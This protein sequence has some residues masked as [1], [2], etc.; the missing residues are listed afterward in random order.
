MDSD[1]T[2]TIIRGIGGF[3]HV[4]TGDTIVECRARG[5][6]RKQNIKPCVGDEVIYELTEDTEEL[7]GVITSIMERKNHF[8]RPPVSNIDQFIVVC[9]LADPDPNYIILDR[10]LLAAERESVDIVICFTKKD[11]AEESVIER[12]K[13]I[14]HDVYP[15]IFLDARD[16]ENVKDMIPYLFDKKSALAGPSGAGK[17]TIL[18]TLRKD[19]GAK[20]GAV[21]EKTGRGRHTTRHVELFRMDFGGMVFDTPGFT[22]FDI[23]DIQTE[24]LAELYPDL[25]RYADNC[26]FKGCLH[27]REPECSVSTAVE[28]GLIHPLRYKSYLEQ[29]QLLKNS[30]KY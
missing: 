7:T 9:A 16:H 15:L 4:D 23:P 11:I 18:N 17:S 5:L 19:S 14:Y 13:E 2:G 29:L 28:R 3:Y 6:F 1:N 27:D 26:R 25:Y 21:S 24:N 22:S 8:L 30:K 10:F 12:V 20:T